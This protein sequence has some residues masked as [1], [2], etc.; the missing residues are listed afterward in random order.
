MLA[1]IELE[2]QGVGKLDPVGSCASLCR[3]LAKEKVC[4]DG[5]AWLSSSLGSFEF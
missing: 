4:A 3:S 1:H 2:E 5:I